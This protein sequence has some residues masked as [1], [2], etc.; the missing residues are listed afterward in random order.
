MLQTPFTLLPSSHTIVDGSGKSDCQSDSNERQVN[1]MRILPRKNWNNLS[2]PDID[3]VSMNYVFLYM[4]HY[5]VDLLWS[6]LSD[7]FFILGGVSYIL[8]TGWDYWLY[9]LD[10]E[11]PV[12]NNYYIA[13]DVFAPTVYLMNSIID[14]NWAEAVRLRLRDKRDL[15][16]WWDNARLQLRGISFT[17][18]SISTN[19][20]FG[21]D[22]D[23]LCCGT[24]WW[25][26]I[27]KHAAH[28]RTLAAAFTF[29][30]AASLAVVAAVLR[31]WFLPSLASTNDIDGAAIDGIDHWVYSVD[32]I[33]D[34]LSD[35]VYILSAL[36]SMTGKRHRPWFAP[37]DQT[38]GLFSDSERLEDLGDL[39]FMIGSLMDAALADFGLNHLLLLPVLSSVLWMVDGCLYMRSDIVKASKLQED[40][41][42][43][44]DDHSILGSHPATAII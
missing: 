24:T 41:V 4:E 15:T 32:A 29:G 17:S 25:Y 9:S 27:R 43:S 8:L 12:P 33:L 13:L 2:L 40:I 23:A 42:S 34:A 7:S 38:A 35:H 6:F 19:H 21:N 44:N 10:A 31:N 30:I 20:D 28:R 37:S 22:T 26:R 1:D 3:D 18:S 14:I 11:G 36:I 39:L 16:K 5:K